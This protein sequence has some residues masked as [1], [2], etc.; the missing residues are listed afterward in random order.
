MKIGIAGTGRMGAAMAMR[1]MSVGHD[2]NVWNRS[3][4]KTKPLAE[5]GAK[6]QRTP[7]E[8]AAASEMIITILTDAS[9]IEQTY[10]GQDGLLSESGTGKIFIEMST[11]RPEV[12]EALAAQVR[13][14]GAALVDCPVG[15]TVDPRV[16]ASCSVSSAATRKTLHARNLCSISLCRRVEH[17]GPIGGGARMK[18][19]I[20]LPL[21][22]YWQALGEALL[23]CKSLALDPARLMDILSDTSGGPN[24]LKARGP[25]IADALNG[26]EVAPVTFDIDSIR[27]DLRTMIEEARALGAALPVTERALAC[28]DEASNEGLGSKDAS[29]LPARFIRKPRKTMTAPGRSKEAGPK[30]VGLQRRRRRANGRHRSG[31]GATSTEFRVS[32]DLFR[33]ANCWA[34]CFYHQRPPFPFSRSRALFESGL[35]L[36]LN[37]RVQPHIPTI[38][39]A[40]APDRG[41]GLGLRALIYMPTRDPT[42]WMWTEACQLLEQ[43][44]RMHRQ[45]FRLT[46]PRGARTAWE[47][48]VN[49]FED[50][51]R[52]I[53][54][55]A[56]P[57]VAAEC[58]EV[59]LDSSSIIVRAS[60][61]LPFGPSAR[62]VRRLEIPYGY[63]ERRIQLAA[64]P[65]EVVQR[66]LVNGCLL[67]NL[68]K[69]I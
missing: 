13:E 21:L 5:S 8:L 35:P 59:L 54:V 46:A 48:P 10:G 45:F 63:F 67:L 17:V 51:E 11:V 1:L 12:E 65:F 58:I 20:N 9:A 52:Y 7:R 26:K 31:C 40:R 47:P 27:K 68:R 30:S 32:I 24:V 22:V 25:A 36:A 43:A 39:L 28:F 62:E 19:A 57:G 3:V 15:G 6:V 29:T 34:S 18:L 44:E 38:A 64:V 16:M 56:L 14:K 60:C 2:V 37:P 41:A 66:E 69:V 4:E 33:N 49:V 61:S 42:A 53:I 23:L 55:V 50:E